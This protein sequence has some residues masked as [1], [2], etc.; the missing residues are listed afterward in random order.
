MPG[1][2]LSAEERSEILRGVSQNKSASEIARTLNREPS[3][4]CR[5]LAR[6]GGRDLYCPVAASA[7]A[8][9]NRARPKTPRLLADPGL[10]SI[11]EERLRLKDSPM[12]ISRKLASGEY[13]TVAVVSHETIYRSVYANGTAGLPIGIHKHLHRRRRSRKRRLAEGEK[14][15]KPQPLAARKPIRPIDLRPAVALERIEVGH[16]EGDL[17]VGSFNQSAV[18]TVFDRTSRHLWMENL[19]CGHDAELTMWALVRLLNRI[20]EELRRTLTW[21]QGREMALWDQLEERTGITV[22]FADP[23]SP[24]QRPTNENG[25]GLIRRWLPKS[26]D[27]SV[28]SHAEIRRIETQINTMPRRSLGWETAASVY[29]DAAVALTA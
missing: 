20:P 5:E 27:L 14:P 25:N 23:H 7:S 2:A 3:T 17:I 4:I 12:T 10:A 18:I 24:W 8:D 28:H 29:N 16:L 21:D 11:V 1:T 13:G 9:R 6:N 22:Y 26:T 19:P 15:T